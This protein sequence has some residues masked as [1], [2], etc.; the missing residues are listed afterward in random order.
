MRCVSETDSEGEF[1]EDHL[2]G[3]KV[4]SV[5]RM[6]KLVSPQ[7]VLLFAVGSPPLSPLSLPSLF[8]VGK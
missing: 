3:V 6:G 1:I 7:T 2:L 5:I 8:R 4:R